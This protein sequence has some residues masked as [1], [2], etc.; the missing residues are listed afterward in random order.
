MASFT[1]PESIAL[2]I[3]IDHRIRRLFRPVP[4]SGEN[5]SGG[6][7]VSTIE[8][9]GHDLR[10]DEDEIEVTAKLAGPLSIGGIVIMLQQPRD[11]HPSEAG[12][13][14][15]IDDCDTLIAL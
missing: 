7:H 4:H 6:F 3:A 5:S 2:E 12:I 10:L 14:A 11:N 8:A 9:F 15:V 13:H 1:F